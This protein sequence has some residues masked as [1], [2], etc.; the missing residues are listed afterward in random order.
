LTGET[1]FDVLVPG[2]FL[3]F[4][5]DF[6]ESPEPGR[7]MF[8]RLMRWIRIDSFSRF[9]NPLFFGDQKIASD[10]GNSDRLAGIVIKL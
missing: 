9:E 3:A 1:P 8:G 5:G 2:G 6:P 4:R 10:V 7:G